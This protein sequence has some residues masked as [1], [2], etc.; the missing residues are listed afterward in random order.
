ML[1]RKW[2]IVSSKGKS[3]SLKM[4]PTTSTTCLQCA[5]SPLDSA[6]FNFIKVMKNLYSSGV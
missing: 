2:G 5:Q 4:M 6:C 3:R 1:E